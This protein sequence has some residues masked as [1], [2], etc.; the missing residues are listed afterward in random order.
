M[1]DILQLPLSTLVVSG[2]PSTW[3]GT[4]RGCLS[5]QQAQGP[6]CTNSM[7]VFLVSLPSSVNNGALRV[8]KHLLP[9]GLVV[10]L[11]AD[12]LVVML[13]Y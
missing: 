2:S 1:V 10:R 13:K 8:Q 7:V 9:V 4:V 12:F 6:D 11:N 3:H 5:H